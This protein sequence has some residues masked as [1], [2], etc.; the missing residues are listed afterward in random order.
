MSQPR[1]WNVLLW[2]TFGV[3]SVLLAMA[4]AVAPPKPKSMPF[5]KKI[6]VMPFYA[7]THSPNSGVVANPLS[8]SV[9]GAGPIHAGGPAVLTTDFFDA[10]SRMRPG[11]R[12]VSPV[13]TGPIAAGLRRRGFGGVTRNTFREV[14]RGV[15]ADAV[16]AC[17]VY[18]MMERVGSGAGV[19][20]P[21]SVA[22]D[23]MLIRT[24]TGTVLWRARFEQTQQ[25]LSENLLNLGQYVKTGLRWVPVRELAQLGI[26]RMISSFPKPK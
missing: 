11:F 22:I 18:R 10:L 25:S 17:F 6:A 7:V 4:C 12:Y 21:A 2:V 19:T 13:A 26:E 20:H 15:N 24:A 1:R 5:I 23:A 16:V 9:F 14:G 3:T 8:G